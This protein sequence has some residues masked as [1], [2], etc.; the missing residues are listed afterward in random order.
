[1]QSD[2]RYHST[3]HIALFL[4]IAIHMI[5]MQQILSGVTP[6]ENTDQLWHLP[7]GTRAFTAH[8]KIL[9]PRVSNE[10]KAM[11]LIIYCWMNAKADLSHR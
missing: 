5:I 9:S 6:S 7:N 4:I 3:I 2:H 8:V 11:I 10:S 1:M